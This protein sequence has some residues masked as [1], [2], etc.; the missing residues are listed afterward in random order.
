[1]VSNWQKNENRD[2]EVETYR[3]LCIDLIA[4]LS[5]L[6]F[7]SGPNMIASLTL[8]RPALMIPSTTVPT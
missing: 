5:N 8:S 2:Q 7:E 1:M 4:V 3:F 6:P